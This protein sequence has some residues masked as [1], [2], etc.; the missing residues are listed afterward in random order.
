MTYTKAQ[1]ARIVQ[2]VQRAPDRKEDGTATWSLKTLERAL[3]KAA[4]PQGFIFVVV[5]MSMIE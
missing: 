2:E 5:N 1:R 3:R 4:L